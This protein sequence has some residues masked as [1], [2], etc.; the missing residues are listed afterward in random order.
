M[1]EYKLPYTAIDIQE[2]LGKIDNMAEKVIFLLN[3]V[4][5]RMILIL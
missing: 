3:K 1:A 4:S 5:Y 2:R